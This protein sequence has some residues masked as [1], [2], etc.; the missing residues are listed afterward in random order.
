[1]RKEY[2]NLQQGY[3]I[4]AGPADPWSAG[5]L[6]S[7]QQ[8][9]KSLP[10]MIEKATNRDLVAGL[11]GHLQETNPQCPAIDGIIK[12]AYETAGE[13][14]DKAALD[15]AIVANAKARAP[16]APLRGADRMGRRTRSRRDRA[17]PHDQPERGEG[18]E[19]QTQ[20]GSDA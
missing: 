10:N 1:L 13:I 6:P 5:H 7:E 12:E 11:K 3:K 17:L 2:G 20:R 19:H 4:D 14:E 8:I 18:R 9:V 16:S 15:A